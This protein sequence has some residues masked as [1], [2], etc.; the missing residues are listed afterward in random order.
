MFNLDG[1]YFVFLSNCAGYSLQNN[2]EQSWERGYPCFVPDHSGEI[3]SLSLFSMTLAVGFFVDAL[4]QLG[5]VLFC[6]WFCVCFYHEKVLDFVK[7]FFCF[8]CDNDIVLIFYSVDIG[9]YHYFYMVKLSCIPVI[10]P[11][12]LW[13]VIIFI[14]FMTWIVLLCWGI[15]S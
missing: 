6:S 15:C 8:Y 1:F 2:V 11:T 7:C 13:Y 3:L 12:W 10:N 4:Y 9:Y 14:C 5:D